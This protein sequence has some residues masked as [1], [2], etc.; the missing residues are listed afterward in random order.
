M[1]QARHG[2]FTVT[3]RKDNFTT[4]QGSGSACN[5]DAFAFGVSDRL[6]FRVDK[7]LIPISSLPCL[8]QSWGRLVEIGSNPLK[9]RPIRIRQEWPRGTHSVAE[10]I[11]FS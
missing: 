5:A 8:L 4:N 2:P 6:F 1:K 10:L 7:E 11:V 9:D 3:T